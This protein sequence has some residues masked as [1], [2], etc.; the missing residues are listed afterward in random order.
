MGRQGIVEVTSSSGFSTISCTRAPFPGRVLFFRLPL[1]ATF[2]YI[3]HPNFACFH[4]PAD[5][6][7]CEE[8]YAAALSYTCSKCS[9]TDGLV[10]AILVLV[11]V[12]VI[13]AAAIVHL[14]SAP[15]TP[16]LIGPR[17][18][19]I[20]TTLL[21]VMQA[22]PPQAVKTIVVSWQILTQVSRNSW[23]VYRRLCIIFPTLRVPKLFYCRLLHIS[24]NNRELTRIGFVFG[25][26]RSSVV[27]R[28]S[29]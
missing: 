14:L 2:G 20:R 7:V 22:I 10:V 19:T 1:G 29:K 17:R 21:K 15:E 28:F 9:G 25:S 6:A 16:E 3:A 4:A 18:T 12:S 23:A 13:L 26:E 5:C 8:D 27:G 24:V 11:V